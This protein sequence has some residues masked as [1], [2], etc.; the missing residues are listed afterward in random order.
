[1]TVSCGVSTYHPGGALRWNDL[2]TTADQALYQAKR[3]GRNRVEFFACEEPEP[4]QR[5]QRSGENPSS[6]ARRV[7][8]MLRARIGSAITGRRATDHP[9]TEPQSAK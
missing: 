1:M 7:S 2:I 6:R 9:A 3:N 8:R 5:V 4:V